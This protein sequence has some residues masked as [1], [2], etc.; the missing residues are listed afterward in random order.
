MFRSVPSTIKGIV[1]NWNIIQTGSVQT[2]ENGR[3]VSSG[4]PVMEDVQGALGI[5]ET[6]GNVRHT[7]LLPGQEGTKGCFLTS[8]PIPPNPMP[9]IY[10]SSWRG[11]REATF[12]LGSVPEC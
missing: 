5:L 12:L 11:C 10:P 3:P 1:A 7:I 8:H 9:A 6:R 2:V 4:L